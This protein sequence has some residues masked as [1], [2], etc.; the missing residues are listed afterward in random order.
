[1]QILFDGFRAMLPA[2]PPRKQEAHNPDDPLAPPGCA[3][4]AGHRVD[5]GCA[6]FVDRL[7]RSRSVRIANALPEH[8]GPAHEEP[9]AI[10]SVCKV[11]PAMNGGG[12]QEVRLEVPS[13]ARSNAR[14]AID[15]YRKIAYHRGLVLEGAR[16]SA[17]RNRGFWHGIQAELEQEKRRPVKQEEVV[18]R[19]RAIQRRE[20]EAEFQKVRLAYNSTRLA[21]G[22][23]ESEDGGPFGL[24][25]DV[26]RSMEEKLVKP[27]L[28]FNWEIYLCLLYVEIEA[29][30]AHSEKIP[31]I[32]D[33]VIDDVLLENQEILRALK[34]YRDKLLHPEAAIEEGQA[35]ERFFAVM[36]N[37]NKSELEVVFVLQRMIDGHIRGI[38]LGIARTLDAELAQIIEIGKS[39][40][41]PGKRTS[42]KFENWIGQ[43]AYEPPNAN[44]MTT[45]EFRGNLKRSCAP[46]L[47]MSALVALISRMMEHR[48]PE[49]R[50]SF[51][52]PELS[53]GRDYERMVM[54][55]FILV[56]EGIGTSDTA[57]LL[58][59]EDP[60]TL[61]LKESV[62]LTMDGAVPETL[63]LE[64]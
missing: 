41:W 34:T 1:M 18:E 31:D 29:Y 10:P 3:H 44:V 36:E 55:A 56:S 32:R 7:D 61:P 57:K 48:E 24:A 8:V 50:S 45:D 28:W 21:A 49:R 6:I 23:D 15:Y 11:V 64:S 16:L 47:S 43:I 52:I 42:M 54:R 9:M 59:S 13:I 22:L 60:R 33:Q 19:I 39:G 35:I 14:H 53:A 58:M 25:H 27:I 40:K 62:K 2:S 38:K 46:N 5:P 4:A 12:F 30:I 37:S 17:M 63:E 26:K 51:K 20:G